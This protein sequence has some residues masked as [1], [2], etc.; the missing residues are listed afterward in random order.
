MQPASKSLRILQ[1]VLFFRTFLC[2]V[3]ELGMRIITT[4]RSR[5]A[6][7]SRAEGVGGWNILLPIEYEYS[8]ANADSEVLNSRKESERWSEAR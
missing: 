4:L 3:G 2:P 7:V 8:K 5:S 6:S 1:H